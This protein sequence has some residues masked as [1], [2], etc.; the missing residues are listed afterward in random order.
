[1][2]RIV[3]STV[4]DAE[5]GLGHTGGRARRDREVSGVDGPDAHDHCTA[6]R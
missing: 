2:K 6:R 1:M 4:A 3:W 5:L